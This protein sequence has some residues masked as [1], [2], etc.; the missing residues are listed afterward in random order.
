MV[1]AIMHGCNG[2]M[3][4]VI[5]GLVKNDAEIEFVAGIDAYTGI[6]NTYPVF[7]SIEKCDVP[8]ESER[9]WRLCVL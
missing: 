4:Q 7:E 9:N 6:A 1:R 8:S 3:G 5:T 2:K